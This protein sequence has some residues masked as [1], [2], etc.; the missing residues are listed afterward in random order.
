MIT[1]LERREIIITIGLTRTQN[2]LLLLV[3][4]IVVSV[5]EITSLPK[6]QVNRFR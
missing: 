6:L 1:T 3:V 4:V 2:P 5:L